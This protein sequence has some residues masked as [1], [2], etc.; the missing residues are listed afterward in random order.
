MESTGER[1]FRLGFPVAIVVYA[2]SLILPVGCRDCRFSFISP[3]PCFSEDVPL[4]GRVVNGGAKC[5]GRHKWVD[6]TRWSG[7]GRC[8]FSCRGPV[9]WRCRLASMVVGAGLSG[10]TLS[11]AFVPVFVGS[12]PMGV[13]S[14]PRGRLFLPVLFDSIDLCFFFSSGPSGLGSGGRS[15]P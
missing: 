1:F 3:S 7:G 2:N 13:L 5:L 14:F 9:L 4:G 10:V 11:F 8:G 6:G 15:L 12:S